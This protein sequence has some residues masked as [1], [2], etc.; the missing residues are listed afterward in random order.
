MA[1]SLIFVAHACRQVREG[2]DI[3]S[4]RPESP[5]VIEITPLEQ[6][7]AQW[8]IAARNAVTATVTAPGADRVQILGRP[9]GMEEDYLENSMSPGENVRPNDPAGASVRLRSRWA[10]VV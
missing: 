3:A 10:R 8:K 6:G 4:R 7:G 9:E 5:P 2:F 1:L